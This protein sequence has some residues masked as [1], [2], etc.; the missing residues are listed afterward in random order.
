[1]AM[2]PE[3]EQK[4]LK[5]FKKRSVWISILALYAGFWAGAEWTFR[6]GDITEVINNI[7]QD[8]IHM[9]PLA[10]P[11]SIGSNVIDKWPGFL[12]L[13]PTN[14]GFVLI[15]VLCA[16]FAILGDYIH[17]IQFK[18]MRPGEEHGSAQ[19]NIGYKQVLHDCIMS[20]KLIKQ[21]MET[22][23][24]KRVLIKG[25]TDGDAGI[26]FRGMS[27]ISD[28]EKLAIMENY[29]G[30]GKFFALIGLN[31]KRGLRKVFGGSKKKKRK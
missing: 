3:R 1:M 29:S 28:E 31:L 4:R 25:N 27:S 16:F 14:W 12:S 5:D 10:E 6:N 20:P 13:W 24:F 7:L 30:I 18:N 8:F 15:G 22:D 21:G 26:L 11:F 17:Y 9:R 23:L 19:F 2:D